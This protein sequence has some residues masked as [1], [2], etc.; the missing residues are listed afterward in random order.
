MHTDYLYM[1]PSSEPI[2]DSTL[3]H[4]P[5]CHL[6]WACALGMHR[7]SFKSLPIA[8]RATALPHQPAML[9]PTTTDLGTLYMHTKLKYTVY[10]VLGRS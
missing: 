8:I 1:F 5:I 2:P 9:L 6:R 10:P 3:T 7:I 4:T